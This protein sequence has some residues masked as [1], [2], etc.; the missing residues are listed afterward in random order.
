M[1]DIS[2]K[3]GSSAETNGVLS[4][5]F[6][7][8]ALR[9]LKEPSLFIQSQAFIA[10]KWVKCEKTFDVFEPATATVLGNAASC[11]LKDFHTAIEAAH[12]GQ[13]KYFDETTAAQRGQFLRRWNDAVL[14]NVEDCETFFLPI[15]SQ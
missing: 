6:A 13:I 3:V 5:E 7:T 10:D 14:A 1:A 12:A 15:N 2:D 4:N 8:T 11:N 9:N